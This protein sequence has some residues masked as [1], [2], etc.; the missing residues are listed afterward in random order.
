MGIPWNSPLGRRL[1]E[2]NGIELP[3]EVRAARTKPE[4]P[5]VKLAAA[6]GMHGLRYSIPL[7]IEPVANG[8]LFKKR[9]VGRAGHD[10]KV[11]CAALSLLPHEFADII[12][13]LLKGYP[14]MVGMTRLGGREMDSDN[15]RSAFK[16]VRDAI[17]LKLGVDDG[18]RLIQW[19]YAQEIGGKEVGCL[20]HIAIAGG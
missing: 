4:K 20:V 18:N 7:H 9:M 19:V 10:R 11:I 14:V 8:G 13:H 5:L 12:E 17:A 16:W 3:S 1:A 15:L 2:M 6:S